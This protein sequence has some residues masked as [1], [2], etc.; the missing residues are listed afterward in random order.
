MDQKTIAIAVILI[1]VVAVISVGAYWVL[2]NPGENGGNGATP[3]PTPT[4]AADATSLQ[5]TVEITGGDSAGTYNYYAKNIGTSNMMIRVEIPLGEMNFTY[6][7][8]GAE[9]K[10][11]ANEGSGWVDLSATFSDQWDLWKP[12]WQVYTDQLANWTSGDWTYTEGDST[13]AIKDIT[14]NPTLD[15]SLF[16]VAT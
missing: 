14:V 16:Q 4:G 3:T 13:F 15:D 12:T 6:I 11:W 10:A 1:V 8:N 2:S 7:V 5:Y 9:Q